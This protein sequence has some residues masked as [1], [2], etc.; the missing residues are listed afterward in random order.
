MAWTWVLIL[1]AVIA[2]VL[3]EEEEE[4]EATTKAKNESDFFTNNVVA[5]VVV[6]VILVLIIVVLVIALIIAKVRKSKAAAKAA[7]QGQ[8][9]PVVVP[10]KREIHPPQESNAFNELQKE[11]DLASSAAPAAVVPAAV[12]KVPKKG[13]KSQKSSSNQT[14][15]VSYKWKPFPPSANYIEFTKCGLG[16]CSAPPG[17]PLYEP[18]GAF[19]EYEPEVAAFSEQGLNYKLYKLDQIVKA[20]DANLF[21]AG[22]SV[23]EAQMKITIPDVV[24]S[25]AMDRRNAELY[26]MRLFYYQNLK[27]FM[28]MRTITEASIFKTVNMWNIY[29][30]LIRADLQPLLRRQ[31][32]SLVMRQAARWFDRVP[33]ELFS[34]TPH[35]LPMMAK[36]KK[37]I[38]QFFD[39]EF[40]ANAENCND[41]IDELDNKTPI[42]DE[43]FNVFLATLEK[44]EDNTC[45]A[46]DVVD[47]VKEGQAPDG[48]TDAGV[49]T[50]TTDTKGTTDAKQTPQTK[51]S[52]EN[53]AK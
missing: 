38:P 40:I 19:T 44:P 8:Q 18:I 30:H 11:T 9:R 25:I 14:E 32:C 6:G 35:P 5:F 3:T 47:D 37:S 15:S 21:T 41:T 46:P 29:L 2:S 22:L 12:A 24:K 1:G 10:S 20:I 28:P 33:I 23:N 52:V 36:L 4:E 13:E 31:L 16:T 48:T 34:D 43:V 27:E 45:Q 7:N 42:P 51:P 53:V 17:F 50:P 39:D 26:R 49:P